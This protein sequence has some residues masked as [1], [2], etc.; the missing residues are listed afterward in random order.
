[1][2]HYLGQS[3]E[4]LS[5]LRINASSYSN[6]TLLLTDLVPTKLHG[7]LGAPE[8]CLDI[9]RVELLSFEAI[10]QRLPPVTFITKQDI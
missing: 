7:S 10:F 9:V 2:P 1:M 6:L 4:L 8:I 5:C 3:G